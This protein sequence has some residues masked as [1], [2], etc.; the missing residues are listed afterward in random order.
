LSAAEPVDGF[1][2]DRFCRQLHEALWNRR[3]MSVLNS[4]FQPGFTFQGTTNRAF[5]GAADYA[6]MMGA[7]FEAIPDLHQQVDEVYWMGNDQDGYLTS[8]RWS[9]E[10]NHQGGGL[11][12]AP[13]GA[14]LQ[15]WGITQRKILAGQV[16]AEWTLFNELD[17]MMQIAAK[18]R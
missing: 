9:A 2:P 3:D 16:V 17:L 15:M 4:A 6:G 12:G 7:L 18:R 14:L 13:S 10:G 11:Y 5:Q 1:D 8:E